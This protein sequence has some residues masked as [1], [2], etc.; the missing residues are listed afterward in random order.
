MSE[1]AGCV[2]GRTVAKG[3]K[4]FDK[5]VVGQDACLR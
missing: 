2:F 4:T 5:A 1:V 3:G